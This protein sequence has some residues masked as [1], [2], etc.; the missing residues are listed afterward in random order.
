MTRTTFVGF[1]A[2]LA[3]LLPLGACSDESSPFSATIDGGHMPG[4]PDAAP[5]APDAMPVGAPDAST[6]SPHSCP[7]APTRVI[8]L[9]DSITNCTVI[10]GPNA[11][12]CV[13]KQ[14]FDHV[15][16][17]WGPNAEYVNAAV[18]GALTAG[19]AQQ[20][21][22]LKTGQP[23]AVLVMIYIGGNDLSPY[24]FQSDAAAMTAYDQIMPGIAANWAGIFAFFED[25]TKFPDGATIVMNNQ[26][27]PFDDCTAPPYNLS[28]LKS[29]LLHMFNAVLQDF[30]NQHFQ[31]TVLVDQYTSY[32]GHGHHYN[33]M[34]CPHYMANAT[35]YMKDLIHANADGNAHL[36][37]RMNAVVDD[38]YGNCT[39]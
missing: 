21:Q 31:N 11:A 25:K 39:K 34:T 23:G 4:D 15:K 33:V 9:G 14:F 20:M 13:S 19:V 29:G 17:K 22:G 1:C 7:P 30:A 10:G 3:A 37:S 28:P 6:A 2:A 38:L 18:G 26:Y 16:Q 35:P 36:S 5:G 32:L 8:V 12:D 24:I 27:N